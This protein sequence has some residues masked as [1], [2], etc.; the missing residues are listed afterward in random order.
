MAGSA[1]PWRWDVGQATLVLLGMAAF[2]AVVYVAVVRGGGV[3]IGRTDSPSLALSV[4]ATAI[5]ALGFQPVARRLRPIAARLA[6]RERAAPYEVLARFR[7]EVGDG[8]GTDELPA[9]MARLLAEAT[10]T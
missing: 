10:G 2:V 1:R 3:L 7:T 9:R 5:V 6:R 8:Y 4:L